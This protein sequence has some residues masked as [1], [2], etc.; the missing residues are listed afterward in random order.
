LGQSLFPRSPPWFLY[1]TP[2]NRLFLKFFRVAAL[3]SSF[4]PLIVPKFYPPFPFTR[5]LT[6]LPRNSR[7]F[8]ALR[9]S[10]PLYP[11]SVPPLHRTRVGT[12]RDFLSLKTGQLRRQLCRAS[13]HSNP[14]LFLVAVHPKGTPFSFAFLVTHGTFILSPCSGTF[15]PPPPWLPRSLRRLQAPTFHNPPSSNLPK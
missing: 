9:R 1:Q 8:T 11:S 6:L 3:P 14:F 10:G 13:G 2:K 4:I 15:F 5:L 12:E 7:S